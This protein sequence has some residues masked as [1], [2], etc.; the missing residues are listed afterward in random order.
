MLLPVEQQQQQLQTIE[1][2]TSV[3][4]AQQPN[5]SC[6]SEDSAHDCLPVSSAVVIVVDDPPP[7]EIIQ[8]KD[9]VSL[10]FL[11]CFEISKKRK[12]V[13]LSSNH[14]GTEILV[15]RCWW[16]LRR[17]RWRWRIS[18]IWCRWMARLSSMTSSILLADAGGGHLFTQLFF[19]SCCCWSLAPA[20]LFELP[21]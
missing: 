15:G 18:C 1:S 19:F 12:G 13:L 14:F 4:S 20:H 8:P 11:F 10:Y 16:W 9:E 17:R 6:L 5:D 21:Y 2:D 7:V 3:V